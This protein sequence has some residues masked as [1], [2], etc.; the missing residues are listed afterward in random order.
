[1]ARARWGAGPLRGV[2]DCCGRGPSRTRRRGL[3]GRATRSALAA[4][5]T[6]AC[7]ERPR[8]PRCVSEERF[9]E[10]GCLTA[11]AHS[12]RSAGSSRATVQSQTQR[13]HRAG[14]KSHGRGMSTLFWGVRVA[15]SGRLPGGHTVHTAEPPRPPS[16]SPAKSA[17]HP[18]VSTRARLLGA[19]RRL[20]R[21]VRPRPGPAVGSGASP[22]HVGRGPPLSPSQPLEATELP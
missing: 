1:M 10:I 7:H 3:E 19:R 4:R 20:L 17:S 11:R 21:S 12:R 15:R 8:V 5:P 13:R 9:S 6:V 16:T 14:C 18:P 22:V 2:P